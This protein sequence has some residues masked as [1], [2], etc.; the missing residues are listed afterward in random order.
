MAEHAARASGQHGGMPATAA[1]EV[2][3]PHRVHTDMKPLQM[4]S[5]NEALDLVRRQAAPQ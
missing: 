2:G 3:V 1:I 4:A 5:R